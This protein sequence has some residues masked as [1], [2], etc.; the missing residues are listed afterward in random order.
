MA[1]LVN[2]TTYPVEIRATDV[3]GNSNAAGPI[4]VTPAALT[5]PAAPANFT[6]TPGNASATVTFSPVVDGAN[7]YVLF[8]T[9]AGSLTGPTVKYGAGAHPGVIVA[10]SLRT[11]GVLDLAVLDVLGIPT[12]STGVDILLN[13]GSGV[14]AN[15]VLYG[16]TTEPDITSVAGTPNCLA[17]GD[18][19]G[20]GIMDLAVADGGGNTGAAGGAAGVSNRG[21]QSGGNSGLGGFSR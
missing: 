5:G 2:G 21:F 1:G 14:F 12:G 8:G 15:P 10:S 4:P 13:N 7:V 11:P 6:A 17:V 9:G 3:N 20:D 19:T 18:L 16:L